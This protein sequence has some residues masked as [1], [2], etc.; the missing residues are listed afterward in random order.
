MKTN[1]LRI[2]NWILYND[3]YCKIIGIYKEDNEVII[4]Y[5]N[6][7]TDYR[8]IDYIEPIEL[9]EEVLL[10]IGFNK[11][12]DIKTLN[13]EVFVWHNGIIEYQCGDCNYDAVICQCKYLHQLQNAYY[14]LTG[15]ELNIE[16]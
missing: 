11:E 9:T 6:G 16:L 12:R 7:E 4:E 3:L 14:L 13:E 8:F 15:Q 5:Y 1:E 10:K 2:G